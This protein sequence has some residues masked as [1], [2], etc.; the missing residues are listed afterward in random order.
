MFIT[1]LKFSE[2]IIF[3]HKWFTEYCNLYDDFIIL[4]NQDQK[5]RNTV[6]LRDV[7]N[8]AS[9]KRR[10]VWNTFRRGKFVIIFRSITNLY[11]AE[12]EAVYIFGKGCY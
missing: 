6:P 7:F 9:G 8:K 3:K 2:F 4:T 10:F 12:I 5:S 1:S 11:Y